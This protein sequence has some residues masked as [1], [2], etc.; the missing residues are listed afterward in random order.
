MSVEKAA[1]EFTQVLDAIDDVDALAAAFLHHSQPMG[2]DLVVCAQILDPGGVVARRP[3]F[4]T[5]KHDWFSY[6]QNRHLFF[7]D[8]VIR[9][10]KLSKKPLVWSKIADEHLT[11][12]EREVLE[13][14]RN[15]RLL[16]GLCV[17]IHGPLGSVAGVSL[18]GE[19]FV[20]D[21]VIETALQMMSIRAFQRATE[22]VGQNK[23]PDNPVALSPRQKECLHWA[24]FGKTNREIATIL[25]ISSHTVKEHIDCAKESLGVQSKI[26]AVVRAKNANLIGL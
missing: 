1:F 7:H 17:P 14:P 2:V 19:H 11:G 8:V 13:E 20:H 15:F 23:L 12:T 21:N 22:L 10:T 9:R 26:E 5:F 24:Q 3:V 18:A 16:D 6:Y 25:G 4:G